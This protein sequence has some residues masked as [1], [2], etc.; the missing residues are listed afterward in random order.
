MAKRSL[1][2]RIPRVEV[3]VQ[4]GHILYI[5]ALWWHEVTALP[6]PELGCMSVSH[7]YE[8]FYGRV[9]PRT[10]PGASRLGSVICNPAYRDTHNALDSDEEESSF[11]SSSSAA[12][13][14]L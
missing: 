4:P 3:V 12:T 13:S 9:Q 7:T 2:E 8:P 5:P 14:G 11:S 1:V 6:H 10:G